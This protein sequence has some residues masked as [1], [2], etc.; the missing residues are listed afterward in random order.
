MTMEFGKLQTPDSKTDIPEFQSRDFGL[1]N[2]YSN[3]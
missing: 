3:H 2:K 1:E